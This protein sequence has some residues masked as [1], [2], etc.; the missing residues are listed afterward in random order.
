M[1]E[2]GETMKRRKPRKPGVS[3]L[4]RRPDK[5]K[6]RLHFLR[7]KFKPGYA[8]KYLNSLGFTQKEIAEL[9]SKRGYI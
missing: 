2:E 6:A 5:V 7:M 4:L 3:M 9:K 8:D 1:V